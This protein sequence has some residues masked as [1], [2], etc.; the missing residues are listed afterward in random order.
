MLRDKSEEL[1]I[2]ALL[3][4]DRAREKGGHHAPLA[5]MIRKAMT[6]YGPRVQL[7]LFPGYVK[8]KIRR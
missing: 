6:G 5:R 3:E 8:P 7:S 4:E 2:L 1:E